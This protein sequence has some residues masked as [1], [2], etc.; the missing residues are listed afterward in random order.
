MSSAGLQ[1]RYRSRPDTRFRVGYGLELGGEAMSTSVSRCDQ[2]I[3]LIDACL[4]DNEV[5]PTAQIGS[6]GSR[7]PRS[8]SAAT[9]RRS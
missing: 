7:L 3:A 2:I 8:T 5:A 6:S 4:A 1:R 9:T